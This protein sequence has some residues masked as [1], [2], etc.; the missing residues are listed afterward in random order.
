MITITCLLA[1]FDSCAANA[2]VI[3]RCAAVADVAAA[4]AGAPATSDCPTSSAGTDAAAAIR[5]AALL[6]A[7]LMRRRNAFPHP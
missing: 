4:D 1:F 6:L 3:G 7:P 2:G 5:M